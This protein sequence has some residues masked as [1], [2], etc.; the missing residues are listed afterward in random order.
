MPHTPPPWP[1]IV[2]VFISQCGDI[3]IGFDGAGAITTL[4]SASV[5]RWPTC[6]PVAQR[7]Y[8][9]GRSWANADQPLMRLWYNNL[10][11]GDACFAFGGEG[12]WWIVSD[13]A[14]P[15]DLAYP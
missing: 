13:V 15:L 11:Q 10:D 9:Q 5:S 3:D 2:L 6:I 1:E 12:G 7:L 14:N 4:H 8:M